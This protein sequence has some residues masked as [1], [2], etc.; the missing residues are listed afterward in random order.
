LDVDIARR[1]FANAHGGI[2]GIVELLPFDMT[3]TV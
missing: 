3:A 1:S 2:P